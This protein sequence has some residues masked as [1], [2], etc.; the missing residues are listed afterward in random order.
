VA[1]LYRRKVVREDTIALARHLLES[2]RYAVAIVCVAKEMAETLPNTIKEGVKFVTLDGQPFNTSA[3]GNRKPKV[4]EN[5]RNW[6]D[7]V[8]KAMGPWG[9]FTAIVLLRGLLV[10]LA[11]AGRLMARLRPAVLL[12]FDD[13]APRPEMA[14]LHKAAEERIPSVLVP[15]AAS[16][17]ESDALSRRDSLDHLLDAGHLQS[18]KRMLARR[19]PNQVADGGWGRM[20]FFGLWETLALA[21]VGLANTRPW[22]HGGGNVSGVAVFGEADRLALMGLGVPANRIQVTGQPSLDELHRVQT[23]RERVRAALAEKYGLDAQKTWIACAVPHTAEHHLRSWEDHMADT[24]ALFL[25][26][27]Q[28]GAQVLLSLHPKSRRETYAGL[29]NRDGMRIISEPLVTVLPAADIFV[30]GYSSTVRWAALLGIPTVIADLA[31]IRYT[32]YDSLTSAPNVTSE[33][34]LSQVLSDLAI[35]PEQRARIGEQ[36]RREAAEIGLVDGRACHR[37]SLMIDEL[38]ERRWRSA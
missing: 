1:I 33:G 27:A 13:R 21:C 32:M 26:M 2:G 8:K 12:V 10:D 15:F 19:F 28:S 25:A 31:Q 36:L 23:E 16:T 18:V 6:R 24:E 30:S 9:P 17:P 20:F 5:S 22:A 4:S 7:R 11:R 37:I 34:E 29:A 3:S 14:V 38:L 35:S